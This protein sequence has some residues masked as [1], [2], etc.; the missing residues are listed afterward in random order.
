[1]FWMILVH[2]KER[3]KKGVLTHKKTFMGIKK[4][5]HYWTPY[6]NVFD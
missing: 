1:M 5:I 2:P 4:G 3:N 6:S